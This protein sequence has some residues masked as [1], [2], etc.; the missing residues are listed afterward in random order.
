MSCRIRGGVFVVAGLIVAG[1][2]WPS[3][4]AAEDV[5]YLK[6]RGATNRPARLR[7]EI[8]DYTGRRLLLKSTTGRE[9]SIP[10]D[11]IQRVATT[12]SAEQTDGDRAF[13]RR[14]FRQ[15][16]EQYRL[17]LAA[18]REPRDWMRRQIL[19][20]IVWCLRALDQ[21]ERAGAYFLI[22]LSRDLE[23]RSFDCI[24]LAWTDQQPLPA[25]V[26]KAQTWL[27]KAE[28]PA[29]VLLGASQL[30]A[31]D[32]HA[33]AVEHLERLAAQA[34]PRIAWLAQAQLW[35]DAIPTAT[36]EE[37]RAW[38]EAI[39]SSD[40]ALR[41]GAY[42]V[43]GSARARHDPQQAALALLKV[44]ILYPR[45]YR[46]AAAALLAAGACLE[47]AGRPAQAAGLYR[48]LANHYDQTP[49]APEARR[50]LQRLASNAPARDN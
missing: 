17:A 23:T 22:L 39:E 9:Q 11:R 1:A 6:P 18:A 10:A 2:L 37:L 49:Q 40:P 32:R 41:A 45:E 25:V 27:D 3:P 46:L 36:P 43:L 33:L 4:A 7:G 16:L 19:A 48:E 15:A 31:S 35:R 34:D 44:P 47:R 26:Q 38:S 12:H 42:Y 20:Q 28:S 14:D 8:V 30:L 29:T 24:P 50:R 13:A 21:P 5:V